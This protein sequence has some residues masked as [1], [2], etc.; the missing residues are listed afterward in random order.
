MRKKISRLN[1]WFFSL[2]L[3]GRF[4]RII[5]YTMIGATA[6]LVQMSVFAV[7]LIAFEYFSAGSA[8]LN[9]G[10]NV[11]WFG[12]LK[13]YEIIALLIAI[14]CAIITGFNGQRLYTF[15]DRKDNQSIR[16]QFAKFQL[17]AISTVIG[18][19]I[20]YTTFRTRLFAYPGI[21]Y[22]LLSQFLAI[23]LM[24]IVNFAIN[25]FIIFPKGKMSE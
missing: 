7:L 2:P 13:V 3:I 23:I 15:R 6:A 24:F 16:R 5:R 12:H 19:T 20:L 8:F 22:K 10:I 21:E 17:A 4:K 14:E 9:N 11:P 18:Q 25:Y 1:N